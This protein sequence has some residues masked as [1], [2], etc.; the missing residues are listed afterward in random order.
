MAT[1]AAPRAW[2]SPAVRPVLRDA[3][4]TLAG[5]LVPIAL[6][7]VLRFAE[8]LNPEIEAPIQHFYIVSAVSAIAFCFAVLV[9]LAAFQN[10][11]YRALF[12]ALGFG[13]MAGLFTIHAISTPGAFVPDSDSYSA[14]SVTSV[15][16]FLSL[17]VPAGFFAVSYT[18]YPA[19]IERRLPFLPIGLASVLTAGTLVTVAA[20]ALAN[21]A[22]VAGLPFAAPPYSFVLAEVGVLLYG[23]AAWR[24]L[25]L[26]LI[27]RLRLQLTLA[28][29]FVLLAEAQVAMV[30]TEIWTLAWWSYHLFMLAAVAIALRALAIER[31]GGRRRLAGIMDT[32]LDLAGDVNVADEEVD[33]IGALSTA[34]ELKDGTARGHNRRVA[35]M[36][37]AIG[38][39][40]ELPA[41][42]LRIL[43][44]AALLHDIGLLGVPDS[45]LRNEGS[46]SAQEWEVMRQHPLMA[47]EMLARVGGLGREQEII[48]AHHERLDGSGY[49]L[50]LVGEEIPLEAR[51]I[52]VADTYDVMVSGR[53]YRHAVGVEAARKALQEEA[54]RRLYRPAVDALLRVLAAV[55]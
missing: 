20:L 46:L 38:R 10:R 11:A 28:A 52:S 51:I 39:Q 4:L 26:Y 35:E 30:S 42:A 9:A 49:P 43:A 48:V 36:A 34:I 40:L 2:A 13:L 32:A 41:S 25:K 44:R 24:Q 8:P 6:L 47:R 5:L 14:R 23:F 21:E 29:A 31:L 3:G 50:G 17:V 33:T 45:I 19:R 55:P 15:S 22:L 7:L 12:L 37:V 54:G 27:S 53:P 1:T 18:S 16:A